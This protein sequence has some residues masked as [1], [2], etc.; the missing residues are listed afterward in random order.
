MFECLYKD[1]LYFQIYAKC[2]DTLGNLFYYYNMKEGYYF[3]YFPDGK[4][5]EKKCSLDKFG[6][7]EG[8]MEIYSQEGQLLRKVL[9]K[10]GEEID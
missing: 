9:Y 8:V 1:S 5:I 6:N 7:L 2:Y 4:T 3:Q 10:R